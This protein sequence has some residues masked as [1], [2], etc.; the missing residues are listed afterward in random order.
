MRSLDVHVRLPK[1]YW[2]RVPC[3]IFLYTSMDFQHVVATFEVQ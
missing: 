2:P 3:A 1:F